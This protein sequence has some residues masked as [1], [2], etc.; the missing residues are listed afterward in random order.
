NWSLAEAR[1]L[2]LKFPAYTDD[3]RTLVEQQNA[4][5]GI[6]FPFSAFNPDLQNPYTMHY[7]F[8]VQ[9]ALTSTLMLETGY[10][11]VRGVKFLMHRRVNLPDRLTGLRPNPN[12]VFGGPYYVDQSQNMDYNG[13][14]TS[15]RKRF[16]RNLSFDTHYTWGKGLGVSGG[17]IGAYY[18]SDP[19]INI[20]DFDNLKLDRG[21]NTGDATHRFQADWIFDLPRLSK[22][23]AAVRGVLGGWQVSGIISLRSGE[24]ITVTEPCSSQWFCRPDV[25]GAQMVL[26]NWKERQGTRCTV[27]ARCSVQYINRNNAFVAVP[28]N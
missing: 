19:A 23:N 18:G 17:D 24:A 20:Q 16:S 6:L 5:S 22:A 12:I 21:P 9:R 25:G 7:Q 1:D 28:V 8:N 26:D 27:G 11:G 14:Q 13:W 2:G 3:M 15:L 10:V 4:R